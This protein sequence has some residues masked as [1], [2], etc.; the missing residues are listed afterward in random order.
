MSNGQDYFGR[1][2]TLETAIDALER[3]QSAFGVESPVGI[4]WKGSQNITPCSRPPAAEPPLRLARS[5]ALDLRS[6]P[7]PA[8]RPTGLPGVSRDL[9]ARRAAGLV[10]A[11]DDARG[12]GAPFASGSRPTCCKAGSRAKVKR[13]CRVWWWRCRI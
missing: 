12:K 13:P 4:D 2:P 8:F 9:T 11:P 5:R 6:A 10:G 7:R 3:F 1:G